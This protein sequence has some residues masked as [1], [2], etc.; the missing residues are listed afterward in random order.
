M[1][2]LFISPNE[3]IFLPEFYS[4][5]LRNARVSDTIS[6]V[7]VPAE[8]KNTTKIGLARR[9]ASTFGFVEA[10]RLAWDIIF[11]RAMDVIQ[12]K[13]NKGFYS[14]RSV[15]AYF[16]CECRFEEDINRHSFVRAVMESGT[17]LIISVSCPQIM[18]KGLIG[19]PRKGCLNVHGSLLPKYRG[20]MPSFWMLANGER[21]A[22]TTLFFVNEKIDAGEVLIQRSFP[23]FPDESLADFVRRSKRV[24]AEVVLVGIE[25]IRSGNYSTT[26]IDLSKGSYF[27]W[28]GKDDVER[29][30][31]N[32]KR[33]R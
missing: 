5:V 9:Y 31:R 16:G 7:L 12:T 1:N 21:E 19:A 11:H 13:R 4:H 6:V 10:S 27:G 23:I 32:G 15:C 30:K 3:P 26:Q 33:L 29:F 24:A 18:K 17:D 28:P 22:G 25:K 2:I 8:Y 20:I 14:I